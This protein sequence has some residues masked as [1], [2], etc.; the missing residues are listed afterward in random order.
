MKKL[1][2]KLIIAV[3]SLFLFAG[4][5]FCEEGFNMSAGVGMASS[6]ILKPYVYEDVNFDYEFSNGIALGGG[7]RLNQNITR[8]VY[9]NTEGNVVTSEALLYTMP[10]LMFQA[11]HFTME[12]GFSISEDTPEFWKSPFVKLGGDFPIWDCG[13]GKIGIDFGVEVWVSTVAVKPAESDG[14][15]GDALA[16][17]IATGIGTAFA[18]IFNIPKVSLGMKYYLPF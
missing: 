5:A 12:G 4:A 13:R 2:K 8:A 1:T 11:G 9:R 14:S 10:Y 15:A 17:G 7:V 18:T 6:L 3:C 16:S